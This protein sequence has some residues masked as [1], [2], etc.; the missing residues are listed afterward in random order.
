MYFPIS[1]KEGLPEIINRSFKTFHGL[2]IKTK[3]NVMV[4]DPSSKQ[5]PKSEPLLLDSVKQSSFS[6]RC[7]RTGK[8]TIWA[9]LSYLNSPGHKET[10]LGALTSCLLYSS[11][12]IVSKSV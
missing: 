1:A 6:F 10:H 2:K 11:M 5:L 7:D 8:D 12:F 4:C 3:K 9:L